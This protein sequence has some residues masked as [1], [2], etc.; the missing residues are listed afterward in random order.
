MIVN[1]QRRVT[2]DEE[3]LKRFAGRLGRALR[4][5]P[6]AFTVALVSD[7]RIAS[8]NLRYRRRARPTDVLAF[9]LSERHGRNGYL[10]DIVISAPTARRNARRYALGTADEIKLLMVHGLLHLLGFDHE[11]DQGQMSRREHA[12]RRRLGLE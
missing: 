5:S 3:D 11:T 7:Q 9:P 10:G 6:Q 1:Q 12:L 8:L 2:V 4:L